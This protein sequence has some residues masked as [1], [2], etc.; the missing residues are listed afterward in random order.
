MT[1]YVTCRVRLPRGLQAQVSAVTRQEGGT[2][3]QF[4]AV[5]IAEKLTT[6]EAL[7]ALAK[8]ARRADMKSFRQV[9]RRRKMPAKLAGR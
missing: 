6:A 9:L 8:R 3:N 5:A 2:I 1:D 4:I 7:E